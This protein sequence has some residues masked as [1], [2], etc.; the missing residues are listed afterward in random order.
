MLEYLNT[1][2]VSVLLF[3]S[4]VIF[5]LAKEDK[6]LVFLVVLCFVL[7]FYDAYSAYSS[8]NRNIKMFRS[9]NTL[10]CTSGGGIY[11]SANKYQVSISEG[12]TLDKNYFIK[13]SLMIRI[14]KCDTH[15]AT[16]SE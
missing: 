15:F 13:D 7:L 5:F 1:G 12:W 9:G 16:S 14:D 11:T 10:V 3:F 2:G 8:A 6:L 4:I